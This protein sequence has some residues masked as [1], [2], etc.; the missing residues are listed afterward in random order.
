M[1]GYAEVEV[2]S[3]AE[4][5]L[6]RRATALVGALPDP[7]DID[8]IR[9]HELARAIGEE[10]GLGI[11]DG[12]FGFTEHS[13]L[14]ATPK[15]DNT[16]LIWRLPN[17]LDVYVPGEV[18]Q[19]QLIHVSSALPMPYRFG[20]PRTDIRMSDLETLRRLLRGSR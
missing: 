2:F 10:L 7:A 12:H 15:V 1:R 6:W 20:P 8:H 4:I 14:W 16:E 9:C 11:Q 18:P 17:I 13:W 5:E 19:V 3:A